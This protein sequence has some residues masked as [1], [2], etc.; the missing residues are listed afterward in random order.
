MLS[1]VSTS[2]IAWALYVLEINV[3]IAIGLGIVGAGGIGR[4]IKL[5]QDLFA[6]QEMAA[7]IVMVFVMVISVEFFSSRIRARLRP[8][9][10]DSRGLVDVIKSLGDPDRWLGRDPNR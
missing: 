1:Q 10:H 8:S 4:Y 9:E 2:F 7:G 3:R 5:R 6:Y